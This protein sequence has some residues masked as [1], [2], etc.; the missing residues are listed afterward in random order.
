MNLALSWSAEHYM[1]WGLDRIIDIT[2]EFAVGEPNQRR[3]IKRYNSC[4]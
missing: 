3:I 1:I 2:L 4:H